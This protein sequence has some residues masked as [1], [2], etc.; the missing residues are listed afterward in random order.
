[1]V[2]HAPRSVDHLGRGHAE[3]ALT[4]DSVIIEKAHRLTAR[5][6][7]KPEHFRLVKSGKQCALVH[8]GT[9]KRTTLASTTCL[10]K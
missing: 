6:L 2:P 1:V 5:E 8:E 7:S 3:D 10:P 9:G 4:K